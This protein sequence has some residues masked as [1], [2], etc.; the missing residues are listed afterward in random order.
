MSADD[1]IQNI[2]IAVILVGLA[3]FFIRIAKKLS[4][5]LK[6]I[7]KMDIDEKKT[8]MEDKQANSK[9]NGS[10]LKTSEQR[11]LEAILKNTSTIVNIMLFYLV[12][13]ILSILFGLYTLSQL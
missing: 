1:V 7:N 9:A 2:I 5:Q 3:I 13:T 12:L 4:K 11:M 10:N 6:H 8:A